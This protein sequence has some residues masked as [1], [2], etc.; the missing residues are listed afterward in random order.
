VIAEILNR[1][2]VFKE[3]E[4]V[5]EH[6]QAQPVSADSDVVL[7]T[8]MAIQH[9]ERS[10]TREPELKVESRRSSN[11]KA[12]PQDD[13]AFIARDP[14]VSL[15]QSA[16]ELYYD[17]R[18]PDQIEETPHVD[19]TVRRGTTTF[20]IAAG[21]RLRGSSPMT[22]RGRRIFDRFSETDPGWVSSVIAMGLRLFRGRHDFND[23]PAT[24]VRLPDRARLILVG[25][26]GS[27]IPRA[28]KVS[29]QMRRILDEGVRDKLTQHVIHLGD[30]YYSGFDWE[31]K[32]RVLADGYWPVRSDEAASVGSW[33]L[34]GNHDMY[35]GGHG[36]YEVLLADPRF[37]RQE[38]SSYFSLFNDYWK[39]LGLDSAWDDQRLHGDQPKWV[40][41][42]VGAHK[43]K[44]MLLSHHQLFSAYESG[45]DE[46]GVA[47]EGPL[48]EGRIDA[49]FWGHEHRCM[50]FR[51]W[52]QVK[53]ARL[54]G[55]GGVPVY[56][57]HDANDP[58][59][60]PGLYEY[61]EFIQR[62]LE[63]W[64]MFGFAVLDFDGPKLH[65]R[66]IDEE[67]TEHLAED[68]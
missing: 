28:L 58:Y 2:F 51:P 11:A 22:R 46:L 62:G 61:R 10:R 59:P 53:H 24:P 21:R 6:L 37:G 36:Y 31:Y 66:Y 33:A 41:R 35:S 27:G 50:T 29:A 8:L 45:A 54:I 44:I 5:I 23:A 13:Y 20:P 47:V 16:L 42:E 49:W 40:S 56:M 9:S 32:K 48:L 39:I 68:I 30:V 63:R 3:M 52:D 12:A 25:D 43:G 7:T 19:T 55:H 38:R 67:G 65:V 18:A 1:T 4:R 60:A 14:V 34:N 26:W 64:A 15:L 57:C 17:E